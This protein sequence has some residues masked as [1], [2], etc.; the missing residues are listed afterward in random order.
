MDSSDG[1]HHTLALQFC[2]SGEHFIEDD[3]QM[4][5]KTS[6][7][8]PGLIKDA[9]SWQL[10]GLEDRLGANGCDAGW[11]IFQPNIVLD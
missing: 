2:Y 11:N 3:R 6:D 10:L 8:K 9:V 5:F 7:N 4:L 1:K